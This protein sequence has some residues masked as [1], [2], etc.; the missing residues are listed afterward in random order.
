M[1]QLMVICGEK[2]CSRSA[3]FFLKQLRIRETWLASS[4]ADPC[5]NV[6]RLRRVR[7]VLS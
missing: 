7:N 6:L 3:T 1:R 4:E 2:N 5:E